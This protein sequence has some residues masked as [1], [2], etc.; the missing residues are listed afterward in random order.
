LRS[1]L[2]TACPLFHIL[3]RK[4]DIAIMWRQEDLPAKLDFHAIGWV[5]LKLVCGKSHPLANSVGDWEHLNGTN[6]SCSRCVQK[7]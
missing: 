1:L 7:V 2:R 4:S 5:P 6:R 3:D